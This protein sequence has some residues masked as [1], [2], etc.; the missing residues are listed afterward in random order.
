V[1]EQLVR[2]CNPFEVYIENICKRVHCLFFCNSLWCR[3]PAYS[4]A[5]MLSLLPSA[6]K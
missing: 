6:N 2:L 3:R 1:K 5:L 4:F